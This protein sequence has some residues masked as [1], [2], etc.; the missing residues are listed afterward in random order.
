MSLDRAKLEQ[1]VKEKSPLSLEQIE[2][3]FGGVSAENKAVV[4]RFLTM[5]DFQQSAIWNSFCYLKHVAPDA[6]IEAIR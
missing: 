2:R 4:W 3:M 1:A 5:P 6:K